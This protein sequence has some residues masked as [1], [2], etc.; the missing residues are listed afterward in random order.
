MK[1][2]ALFS[3]NDTTRAVEFAEQLVSAGWKILASAETVK[4]LKNKKI[5]VVNIADFIN[6]KKNFGFPP[7]LHPKIE[8]ALTA[9]CKNSIDLVYVLTYP[10]SK[11]RDVGGH[12]ILALAA[13]GKRIP[14]LNNKDMEK[15]VKIISNQRAISKKMRDEF[16]AK[17]NYQNAKF[18]I[19]NTLDK[20]NHE[21]IFGKKS[22]NL[23][24]GENP[25]QIPSSAFITDKQDSLS[26]FNLKK[27]SGEKPCFT[28]MA[29]AD[30]IIKT[31]CLA[32]E[33]FQLNIKRIPYICIA[34]KHGN[35]C[36]IGVNFHSPKPS[37]EMALWGNP[38]SVWGGELITNFMIDNDLA[39]IILKSSKRKKL[40]NSAFWMLDLV[41]APSFSKNVIKVLGKRKRRKLFE[42]IA[43]KKPS[44][45][46]NKNDL[47]MVR[48]GFLMQPSKSYIL[49]LKKCENIDLKNFNN[50][51]IISIIIAWAVAFS[52]NH[53]GNEV[54]I[55]KDCCLIGA[56]GGPSTLEATKVAIQRSRENG[57]NCI[58]A[59]FAADAFFPFDDAPKALIEA[60]CSYGIVPGGGKM[61]NDIKKCFTDNNVACGFIPE[62]YRGFCRH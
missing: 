13:K 54:A 11:G 56:G 35:A 4:V 10:D 59:V 48:G 24:N 44:T 14:V 12:T 16:I 9:N 19:N 18:Y 21:I 28:N 53:G 41:I 58:D 7:T 29:D 3:L 2:T 49:N 30:C 36:G 22:Y 37:I 46:K 20:N 45:K 50:D 15:V 57:H 43:L 40:F 61:F 25:Y 5:P 55:V 23:L 33:A 26:L 8:S 34:A 60:G 42:N 52:S 6:I 31:L 39:E 1:G 38:R 62:K 47:R 17:A 27:I 32:V 51:K